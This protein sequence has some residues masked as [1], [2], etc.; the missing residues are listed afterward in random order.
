MRRLAWV[1]LVCLPGVAEKQKL[2]EEERLMLIRGLMAESAKAKVLI[3]RSKKPL[4]GEEKGG[5]D[6][7]FWEEAGKELGVAARVGELVTVTKVEIKDDRVELELNNGLKSGRT[8]RDRVQVGVGNSTAPISRSDARATEG[9]NIAVVFAAKVTTLEVADVKRILSTVLDFDKRTVTENYMENI[10]A[11]IR[12]A[13]QDK[14]VIEG[15][16]REQVLAAVGRPLRKERQTV[17]GTDLE[18]WMYGRA[19]GKLTFVTFE[20]N[21]VVKVKELYAG[22]GGSTA[23]DLPVQE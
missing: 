2:T 9:S 8:G 20:G 7:N 21:K 10:P 13:I 22:L 19:P 14:R 11:P 3:P 23:A 1:L 4:A 6:K 16:D 5:W 18:D 17:D 12:K 15:M